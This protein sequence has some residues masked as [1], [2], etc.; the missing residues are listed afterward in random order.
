MASQ[1]GHLHKQPV[2][3]GARIWLFSRV[4]PHVSLEM[5]VAGESL[6]AHLALERL[7]TRVCALMVLQHV[8]VAE[9]S[10]ARLARELLVP[11]VLRSIGRGPIAP[12]SAPSA[13]TTCAKG[14]CRRRGYQGRRWGNSSGRSWGGAPRMAS[15]PLLL[16]LF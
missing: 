2:A 13:P 8:L 14:W 7:F 15:L 16:L 11:P 10:V 3:V 6:G 12:T 1:I 9:A 5:V 4:Q